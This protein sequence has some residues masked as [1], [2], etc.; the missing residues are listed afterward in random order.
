MAAWGY[1]VLFPGDLDDDDGPSPLEQTQEA[2]AKEVRREETKNMGS[3]LS[4][5]GDAKKGAN[6]FKTRCAQCHTVVESE[7]NKIGPNLHGLFGRHTGSVEGFSYT[8]ANKQ[9]NI[10]WNE[11][12]LFEYLE[13]PKKYIPGTKMAFGGLKKGKDRND[14]I[15]WLREETKK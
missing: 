1:T 6:L 3:Q 13:N 4:S 5:T 2:A 8:D 15:T 12:T 7:G 9:K 10:E 14:L 11:N